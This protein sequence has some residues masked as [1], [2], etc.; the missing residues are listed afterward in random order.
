MSQ[1]Q[2]L[3]TQ[4]IKKLL[5]QQA[6]PA[7]IGFMVM[8]IYMVVDTIFVG[9]WVGPMA[10][11]AIT[12]VMPIS[13]L[14]SSIG[15]AI[16]VGGASVIS[17]AL[18]RDDHE[19]GQ[20]TFGN[21]ITLTVG[22]S[23]FFVLLGFFF[24]DEILYVFGAKGAILG[25]AKTYF[26]ILLIG[27]PFLAW[28]MMSNPNIRA[29]GQAKMAMFTLLIPAVLNLILDPIF[30]IVFDWGLAG[31]AWAT[32]I[33]Y[34]CSALY[35]LLF[36]LRGKGELK[37]RPKN[38][39]LKVPLVKEIAA[40][41]GITLVRQ[42]SVSILA[43]VVIHALSKYGEQTTIGGE[44]AVAIYGI[45]NRLAMFAFF[46]IIGIT[47]GFLPIAGFNYGAKLHT[48]VKEV[49]KV[50][51]IWG[52]VIAS[53]IY[54]L[55]IV[56]AKEIVMIFTSDQI[57]LDETPMPLI[58]IFLA[59][60]LVTVQLV[61]SGYF[62]AIGKAVPAMLLTLTKQGFFLVPLI[63]ILPGV[64]GL[65]IDG[66]WY[67]FPIADVLAATVTYWYLQ[68][69]IKRNINPHIALES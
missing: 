57:L 2:E 69:E 26:S 41:G 68:R 22:L 15:M 61:G 11:G 16:G 59:T 43:I 1:T 14:I 52:T 60:P 18:G 66:I 8:S 58:W 23:I 12:V 40:I 33:S 39:K 42:G 65:G 20:L 9:R 17:R 31:A 19:H 35:T 24:E 53:G 44:N 62:Q 7:A 54:V 47:Q 3:G 30:I 28:A 10:I 21:Q 5:K 46:P 49:I 51:L 56:F 37:I 32:T 48:R 27:I 63:L 36:F 45:I 67:A 6:I 55:I 29:E 34:I 4:P 64:A 50:S 38:F 25:P 13:F